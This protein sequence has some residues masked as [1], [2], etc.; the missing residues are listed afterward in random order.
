M[1]LDGLGF[2]P[3][4][5]I[6]WGLG[7]SK[8]GLLA[9]PEQRIIAEVLLTGSVVPAPR[10]A[11][12]LELAEIGPNSDKVEVGPNSIRANIGRTRA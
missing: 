4:R 7:T 9:K 1:G 6:G 5:R 3:L 12:M 8:I 11:P 10:L 2:V